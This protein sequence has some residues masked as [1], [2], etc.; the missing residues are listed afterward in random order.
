MFLDQTP[1]ARGHKAWRIFK[2][3]FF[4]EKVLQSVYRSKKQPDPPLHTIVET[5]Q[6]QTKPMLLAW[7]KRLLKARDS[8]SSLALQLRR[9]RNQTALTANLEQDYIPT[10]MPPIGVGSFGKM[11]PVLSCCR[12]TPP[13]ATCFV[14]SSSH[15][16]ACHLC[17]LVVV[18]LLRM[19]PP[20]GEKGTGGAGGEKEA[21]GAGVQACQG[22]GHADRTR[23]WASGRA[24]KT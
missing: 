21:A 16:T 2:T 24:V 9:V 23:D 10:V 5:W 14:L 17:C 3:F 12:C 7:H 20:K 1:D 11:H 18:A 8:A 4:F 22:M 6:D 15:S 13:H 19:P